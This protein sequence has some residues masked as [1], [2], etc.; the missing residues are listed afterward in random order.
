MS[1]HEPTSGGLGRRQFLAAGA[2]VPA[3]AG[4]S[5]TYVSAQEPRAA[6]GKVEAN[7]SGAFPAL[8]PAASSRSATLG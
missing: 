8:I 1:H 7:R 3:L 2:A 4:M 6:A 5:L